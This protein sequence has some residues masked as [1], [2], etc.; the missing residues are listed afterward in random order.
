ME[1]PDAIIEVRWKTTAEGGRKTPLYPHEL[2]S[3]RCPF[4]I[5]GE[6]FDCVLDITGTAMELGETYQLP[7]SFLCWNLV[8]PRLKD[9]KFIAL[10][11]CSIV[12]TGKV[13]RVLRDVEQTS[14]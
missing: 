7:V 10:R 4:L 2:D 5:D 13:V 1:H 14:K 8:G 9:G 3:F 12:A 6:Y 11:E